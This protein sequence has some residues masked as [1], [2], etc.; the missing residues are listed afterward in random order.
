VVDLAAKEV[1]EV[2]TMAAEVCEELVRLLRPSLPGVIFAVEEMERFSY[3]AG[4]LEPEWGWT[5]VAHQ[6]DDI[7]RAISSTC[8]KL[9]MRC[10]GSTARELLGAIRID[11]A[12][13]GHLTSSGLDWVEIGAPGIS[14]AY[15]AQRV[16]D[17]LGV[18]VSEVLAVGDNHNDLT[19][20]AWAG[21]AA[22]PANAIPE[23]LAVVQHVIP[24]NSEDGVAQLLEDLAGAGPPRRQRKWPG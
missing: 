5:E 2:S 1:I 15:A 23:V 13:K 12:E 4:F 9:I 11:V 21:R 20:L 7:A 3:E 19:V 6:V 22:A 8:V 17:R 24:P 14:K 18:R 10:P 16:C